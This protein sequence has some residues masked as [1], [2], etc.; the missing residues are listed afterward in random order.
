M[1]FDKPQIY[2]TISATVDRIFNQDERGPGLQWYSASELTDTPEALQLMDETDQE[3]INMF[4][5]VHACE[6]QVS[7]YRHYAEVYYAEELGDQLDQLEQS[8][9][10]DLQYDSQTMRRP[11]VPAW[12]KDREV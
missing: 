11:H 5:D 10:D 4:D 8:A 9:L 12:V 7:I 6:L 1:K 3:C 2:S